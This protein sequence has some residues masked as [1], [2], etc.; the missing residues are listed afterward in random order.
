MVRFVSLCAGSLPVLNADVSRC[1]KAPRGTSKA[2]G[3][4]L[5][6]AFSFAVRLLKTQN[7]IWLSR[8]LSNA[9]G[10]RVWILLRIHVGMQMDQCVHCELGEGPQT[11]RDVSTAAAGAHCYIM[12]KARASHAQQLT[13]WVVCCSK[14]PLWW[15]ESEGSNQL[16]YGTVPQLELSLDRKRER[17]DGGEQEKQKKRSKGGQQRSEKGRNEDL[18]KDQEENKENKKQRQRDGDRWE[19]KIHRGTHKRRQTETLQLQVQVFADTTWHRKGRFSR[20]GPVGQ[21]K[22]NNACGELRADI[23]TI[24][25]GQNGP[26]ETRIWTMFGHKFN[27]WL[28]AQV[29]RCRAEVGSLTTELYCVSQ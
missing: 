27:Y 21:N 1:W 6:M 2:S 23:W 14:P 15:G 28:C 13:C 24:S 25:C 29:L 19:K 10:G 8:P 7:K 11:P 22:G 26:Q 18:T 3:L 17:E 4:C 12:E 9:W 20:K 5:K 16:A